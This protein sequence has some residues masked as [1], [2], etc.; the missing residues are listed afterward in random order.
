MAHN[1]LGVTY[2]HLEQRERQLQHM[3]EAFLLAGQVSEPERLKI[4]GDYYRAIMD[5]EKGCGY[6]K[7]LADLQPD[8][9]VPLV[10]LGVCQEETF[11][12]AAGLV[13][14]EKAVDMLPKSRVR[15]NL[16]NQLFAADQAEK[17]LP[18]AQALKQEYPTDVYAQR[19][20]GSIY[21]FLGRVDEARKT[22][23]GMVKVQGDSETT[24]HLRL[25]DAALA[26]GRHNEARAELDAAIFA[27]DKSGNQFAAVIART[28]LA[29][30]Q[31]ALQSPAEARKTLGELTSADG[32]AASELLTESL[33]PPFI[34]GRPRSKDYT[35]WMD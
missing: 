30:P 13:S 17:A 7:L 2:E 33:L 5:Y 11:N 28:T 22:F 18:L 14:T 16:A 25:A 27:A 35:G 19:V 26:T 23:D 4:L 31:L 3:H 1:Y 10:N 34:N 24:G 8:D 20:L 12:A 32:T 6:E 29:D 9:P 21:L 15:I